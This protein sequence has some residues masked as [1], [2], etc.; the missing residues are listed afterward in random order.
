[1]P[2]GGT[3]KYENRL[4]YFI[5]PSPQSSPLGERRLKRFPLPFGERVRVRGYP[6]CIFVLRPLLKT[7]YMAVVNKHSAA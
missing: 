6:Q 7:V 2:R 1:M 5:S 3:T 4:R